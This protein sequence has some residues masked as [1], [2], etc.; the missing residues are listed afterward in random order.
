MQ[1]RLRRRRAPDRAVRG[2][3]GRR[4]RRSGRDDPTRH[5]VPSGDCPGQRQRAVPPDRLLVRSADASGGAERLADPDLGRT[6]RRHARAPPRHRRRDRRPRYRAAVAAMD[7]HFDASIG[8][9]FARDREPA[10]CG[11]NP[12]PSA[13]IATTQ[14]VMASLAIIIATS[15]E[16]STRLTEYHK[17]VLQR[18]TNGVN[19]MLRANEAPVGTNDD[20][21]ANGT[22]P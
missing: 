20:W 10:G 2:S 13:V 22:A 17:R 11:T 6:A 1:R 21:P 5:S 15:S 12:R 9:L 16:R 19:A 4:P 18:I 14:R 3:D 8:D 7:A